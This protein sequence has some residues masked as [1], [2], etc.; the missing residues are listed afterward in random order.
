MSNPFE[1]ARY[2]VF[3]AFA[4]V[5]AAVMATGCGDDDTTSPSD[6][7]TSD[8]VAYPA[9]PD[10]LVAVFVEAYN[11]RD[12]DALDSVLVADF[13]FRFGTGETMAFGVCETWGKEDELI[14]AQRLFEGADGLWPDGSTHPAASTSPFSAALTPS[15]GSEW[16]ETE[17]GMSRRFDASMFVNLVDFDIHF[18]GGRQELVVVDMSTIGAPDGRP[19]T[20]YG[21]L[22]WDDLGMA[23]R[24]EPAHARHLSTW[25]YIK[26][27]FRDPPERIVE[28]FLAEDF[29][30][31]TLE[32]WNTWAAAGT[33][34]NE[35]GPGFDL[36][37]K[38]EDF[39][40]EDL[41]GLCLRHESPAG[42]TLFAERSVPAVSGNRFRFRCDVRPFV[43]GGAENAFFV[44]W[45][46]QSSRAG[47]TGTFLSAVQFSADGNLTARGSDA[48][49]LGTY[50][51]GEWCQVV[52]TVDLELDIF[53]LEITGPAV[54]F[55]VSIGGLPLRQTAEKIGFV[56]FFDNG[57]GVPN[58]HA[59]DNVRVW[60]ETLVS[61]P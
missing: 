40:R 15:E 28:E 36:T 46:E 14:S 31:T 10:S 38:G 55:P 35:V 18:V 4:V 32:E 2:S 13:T 37:T 51:P 6:P 43:E 7:P 33:S 21:L 47:E 9:T 48:I 17:N 44:T 29:E 41:A 42:R 56:E 45:G 52:F 59:V 1:S 34:D 39:A 11:A 50:T 61:C 49:A 30:E 22:Q 53:D 3:L 25:G 5:I 12:V 23:G 16:T 57:P 26:A 20:G 24:T 58:A 19:A 54:A 8:P 60:T 27:V